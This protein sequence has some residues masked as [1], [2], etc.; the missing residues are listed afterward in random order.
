MFLSLYRRRNTTGKMSESFPLINAKERQGVGVSGDEEFKNHPLQELW[1]HCWLHSLT[2]QRVTL[3]NLNLRGKAHSHLML[4]APLSIRS[5][6]WL[7]MK[8]IWAL[9]KN[10][11]VWALTLGVWWNWFEV[12]T[13]HQYIFLNMNRFQNNWCIVLDTNSILYNKKSFF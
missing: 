11:D 6:P 2:E 1:S 5:Q 8:F 10:T 9:F 7:H 4:L 3:L 13:G 12:R